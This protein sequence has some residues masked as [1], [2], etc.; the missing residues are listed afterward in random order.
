MDGSP[1]IVAQDANG[2]TYTV[3]ISEVS[4]VTEAAKNGVPDD[5]IIIEDRAQFTY[6]NATFTKRK[7]KAAEIKV[8]KAILVCKAFHARRAYTY[9]KNAF[10]DADIS[11]T[12]VAGFGISAENWY[13]T[14]RGR[15]RVAG[16]LCR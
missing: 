1:K 14:E 3:A 16:E 8:E 11:V 15:A 13:K 10:P 4:R 5:A 6:Q 7:L 9:Y 12:P 2:N